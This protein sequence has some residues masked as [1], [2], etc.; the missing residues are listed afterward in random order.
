MVDVGTSPAIFDQ[1]KLDYLNGFYIRKMAIGELAK[2]AEP[3]L[4][5]AGLADNKDK[6][7]IALS[8][9]QE[10]L[11]KL[12]EIPAQIDFFFKPPENLAKI[13][14]ARDSTKEKT[15]LALEKSYHYLSQ[16]KDFGRDSLEQLLRAV[17]AK[18]NLKAGEVL[19]PIRVALTGKEAS[20][21]AFEVLEA[22]GKEESLRR[23]K[24]AISMIE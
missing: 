1:K 18:N 17:A 8:L 14:V 11:K 19:W 5:K 9:V 21:G 16:E 10:R 4:E 20:P 13:L 15:K 22:L 3:F 6:L 12:S 2:A 23:I 24:K 7:L